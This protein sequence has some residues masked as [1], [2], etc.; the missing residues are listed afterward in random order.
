MSLHRP[1]WLPSERPQLTIMFCDMV[2]AIQFVLRFLGLL[3]AQSAPK[4][5]TSVGQLVTRPHRRHLSQWRPLPNPAAC[6]PLTAH[7]HL[8][9]GK[10]YRGGQGRAGAGAPQPPTPKHIAA[11]IRRRTRGCS[12]VI[13]DGLWP[14]SHW[15]AVWCKPI[16]CNRGGTRDRAETGTVKQG[17]V[18]TTPRG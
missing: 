17:L 4:V 18:G 8:G 6:A 12:P 3:V 11:P 2:G 15:A 7:C 14:R 13:S 5:A 10:L 1:V 9:L 16:R